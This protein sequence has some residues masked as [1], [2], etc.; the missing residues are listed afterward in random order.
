MQGSCAELVG[1]AKRLGIKTEM[2]KVSDADP[3]AALQLWNKFHDDLEKEIEYFQTYNQEQRAIDTLWKQSAR[4][5]RRLDAIEKRL[6]AMA[7]AL[8]SFCRSAPASDARS[9]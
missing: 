1:R 3:L 7:S 8:T 4:D 6:D 2:P 5:A 9:S